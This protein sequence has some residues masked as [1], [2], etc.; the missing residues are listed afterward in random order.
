MLFYGTYFEKFTKHGFYYMEV[1]QKEFLECKIVTNTLKHRL[2]MLVQQ[3]SKMYE[4][5]MWEK[6]YKPT[7][8]NMQ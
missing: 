6:L 1:M 5:C 2:E 8:P 7:F 3:K 4:L